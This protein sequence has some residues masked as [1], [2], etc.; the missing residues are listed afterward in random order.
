[1]N[2]QKNTFSLRGLFIWVTMFAV[3]LALLQL[4]RTF[5]GS[6]NTYAYPVP[7]LALLGASLGAPIGQAIGGFDGMRVGVIAGAVTGFCAAMIPLALF[8]LVGIIMSDLS[9]SEP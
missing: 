7:A 8:V 2:E 4:S 3:S 1:M 5:S 9:L 6:L